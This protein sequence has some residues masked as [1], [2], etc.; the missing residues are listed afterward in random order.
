MAPA[1]ER[2]SEDAAVK[3]LQRL[4]RRWPETLGLFS[5]SGTL[6]VVRLE[7]DGSFPSPGR[8]GAT[9][10]TTIT[11]IDIPNDGGDPD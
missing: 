3:A 10:D 4:A 8:W 7:E 11:E 1:M 5:A 2:Y 9:R 6:L